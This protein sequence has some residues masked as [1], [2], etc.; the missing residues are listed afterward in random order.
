M[1]T[2]HRYDPPSC[3]LSQI[4]N[5]SSRH[6]LLRRSPRSFYHLGSRFQLFLAT[7]WL[8]FHRRNREKRRTGGGGKIKRRGKLAASKRAL[9]KVVETRRPPPRGSP[10]VVGTNLRESPLFVSPPGEISAKFTVETRPI[11]FIP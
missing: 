8:T 10:E 5:P 4:L 2:S 9:R 7:V 6:P 3:T 1:S 11:N